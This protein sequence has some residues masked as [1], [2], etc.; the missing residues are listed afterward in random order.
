M[1]HRGS[2]VLLHI[3]SLPSAHGIGDLGPAA[4]AFADLLAAAKQSYWQVLPLNPTEE[5]GS[6][7]PYYSCSSFAAN[8]LFISLER[9]V[10]V[11]LLSAR[12]CAG[13][14][15]FREDIVDFV[16]VRA[17]KTLLLYR[18]FLNFRDSASSQSAFTRFCA[19]Q[20][21]WLDDHA[22]FV[23][24]RRA[25]PDKPWSSW[26]ARLRDRTVTAL[27][28]ARSELADAVLQEKFLQ[29]VFSEQ[30]TRLR[31]HCAGRG[32]KL[33]GDLP[34][35]VAH[36]S[37][38]V[39]ANPR[40]FKLD[41]EYLPTV[42]AGV[43]PDYFSATGQR[44]GNPVYDWAALKASGFGWWANRMRRIASL[45]D[46]VRID[47]FRGLVQYWEIPASEPTAVKGAWCPVPTDEFLAVVRRA[48]PQL[49]VIA[50]DLGLITPDVR[51]VMVRHNLPG[52]KVLLF[53]FTEDGAANPYLPHNYERAT[54]VYTGTH[55]NPTARGWFEREVSTQERAR[56]SRYLGVDVTADTVAAHLVQ[57]AMASVAD[58]C[59]A[60]LQDV[61]ALGADARM[62]RPA[63]TQGNWLWRCG[64]SLMAALPTSRLAE[65]AAAYGRLP[66]AKSEKP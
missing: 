63:T 62:N 43:P 27:E 57:L 36:D 29:F 46:V 38:D 47:H 35:Y 42:V 21:H 28:Q 2:G 53:A 8:P 16:A 33:I 58:T 18:A 25:H 34:I 32:I 26:P 44:W 11:G 65:M 13:A 24:L 54:V 14:P 49:S 3:S 51:E 39:W 5:S 56:M 31:A 15:A 52:M 22:L 20:R 50:E 45:F 7:S 23:A 48:A 10:D 66:H 55:D 6:D 4:F 30:W 41:K 37:A 12:D 1:P 64:P 60:P 59:M 9:L 17:Y 61:L 40:M 19:D